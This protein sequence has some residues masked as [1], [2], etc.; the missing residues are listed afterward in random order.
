MKDKQKKVPRFSA[1]VSQLHL[2]GRKRNLRR[3][4]KPQVHIF[5]NALV[6][7]R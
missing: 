1:S 5:N 3:L 4:F 6:M 7:Q 2:K